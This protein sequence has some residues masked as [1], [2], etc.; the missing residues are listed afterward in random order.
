M[1][2]FKVSFSTTWEVY[3]HSEGIIDS[4]ADIMFMLCVE[5]QT[6]VFH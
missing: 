3:G 4:E 5:I 2:K 6:L 1:M